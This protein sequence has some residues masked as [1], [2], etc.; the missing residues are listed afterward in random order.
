[1]P[2]PPDYPVK[3]PVSGSTSENLPVLGRIKL[4]SKKVLNGEN[5]GLI[6]WDIESN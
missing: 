6:K 1:M 2:I 5:L 3:A 4:E